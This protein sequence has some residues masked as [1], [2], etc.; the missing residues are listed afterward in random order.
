[1]PVPFQAAATSWVDTALRRLRAGRL[2][3][4][5]YTDTTAQMAARGPSS[6]L[7]TYRAHQRA[8]PPEADPGEQDVTCEVALD[9]LPPGATTS[10]QA[11]FLR[12]WGID[13][14][15][16]EGRQVWQARAH[17]GDLQALRGRSRA[18]E[19][20]ALLDPDGLGGFTVAEWAV[21]D[22]STALS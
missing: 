9:Q 1:V 21:G 11:E 14:L 12:R 20:E 22:V 18:R 17:L 4:I 19:S 6:W 8:G 13:A 15:V 10:T 2:V 5:D 3:V 7:R 16:E